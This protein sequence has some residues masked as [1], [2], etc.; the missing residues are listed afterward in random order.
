MFAPKTRR[1]LAVA[2]L[3]FAPPALAQES[4]TPLSVAPAPETSPSADFDTS[5]R[6]SPTVSSRIQAEF[7]D[8]VRWSLGVQT[9]DELAAAFEERPPVEIWQ[10]LVASQGLEPNNVADALTAYWVLNWITANG[11]YAAQVDN[12]PVQRQLRVAFAND[13]NFIHMGD[14]EKQQLAE[15]YMLNFL[16]EHAVLNRAI[17]ARN[18]DVLNRLALT[19]VSR[20]QRSMNV[21]LLALV[22][23][24]DGFGPRQQAPAAAEPAAQ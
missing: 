21:N 18:V 16:L 13:P 6:A 4:E 15:G 2:L 1:L 14:T 5:Y 7:L 9:R 20:F 24:P 17:A 8:S 19:S 11:A 22:P 23:G 10:E 3:A 12:G